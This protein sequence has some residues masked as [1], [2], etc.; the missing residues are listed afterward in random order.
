MSPSWWELW[1]TL[2]SWYVS[3]LLSIILDNCPKI[4]T[5]DIVNID[6]LTVILKIMVS[7][8]WNTSCHFWKQKTLKRLFWRSR[9]TLSYLVLQTRHDTSDIVFHDI[10]NRHLFSIYISNDSNTP[11]LSPMN[12]M[13]NN[14]NNITNPNKHIKSHIKSLITKQK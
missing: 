3:F 8:T 12:I 2:C 6:E 4:S 5:S 14:S 7:E 10:Q 11:V 1:P 9:H 13:I